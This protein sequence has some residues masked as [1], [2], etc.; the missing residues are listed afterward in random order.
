MR[1]IERLFKR[2][3]ISIVVFRISSFAPPAN[4]KSYCRKVLAW[5][6]PLAKMDDFYV[7]G[8]TYG[9]LSLKEAL[10][11]YKEDV[12]KHLLPNLGK[13]IDSFSGI[14]PRLD[15]IVA[16]FFTAR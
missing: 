12:R 3:D 14:G 16:L 2:A 6:F 1:F 13:S 10:N 7:V 9:Y 11:L 5:R 15:R 8:Y 4:P